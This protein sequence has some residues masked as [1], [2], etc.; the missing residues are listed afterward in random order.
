M[1]R[2]FIQLSEIERDYSKTALER[3]R[4]RFVR[5]LRAWLNFERMRACLGGVVDEV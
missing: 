5:L 2:G 3:I 4:V 1:R